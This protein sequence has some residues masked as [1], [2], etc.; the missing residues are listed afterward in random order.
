VPPTDTEASAFGALAVGS[1]DRVVTVTG[2]LS[3][4]E[5]GAYELHVR[6]YAV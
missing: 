6:E 4:T 1:V 2:P 3:Q 5:N